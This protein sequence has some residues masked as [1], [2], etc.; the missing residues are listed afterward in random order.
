MARGSSNY[1]QGTVTLN[2]CTITGN[3][4]AGIANES[5]V[6]LNASVVSHNQ[7]F[8]IDNDDGNVILHDTTVEFNQRWD[9][10]FHGRAA[11]R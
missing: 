8:G 5:S 4:R 7:G 9:L 10:E 6:T 11:G 3:A 2:Q 1:F